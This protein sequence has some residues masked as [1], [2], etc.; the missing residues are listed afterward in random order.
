MASSSQPK[1]LAFTA[2]ADLSSK[3]YCFVKFG[4]DEKTVVLCGAGQVGCGVLQN[5]PKSGEV[6]EVAIFGA[7]AKVKCAGVVTL[8]GS[9]SSDANGLA[10]NALTTEFC[11]GLAYKASVAN[12]VIHAELSAHIKP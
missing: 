3:Q 10:K 6:A 5:A 11:F 1:I 7:G 12:E 2:G 8:G 4:A 9:I